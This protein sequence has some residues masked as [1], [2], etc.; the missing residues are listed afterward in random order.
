VVCVFS[1]SLSTFR[2]VFLSGRACPPTKRYFFLCYSR[3]QVLFYII[4]STVCFPSTLYSPSSGSDIFLRGC[5]VL[6][7]YSHPRPSL[8]FKS[9][10]VVL[11]FVHIL[12]CSFYWYFSV[13]KK[14]PLFS[15]HIL[16]CT[17]LKGLLVHHPLWPFPKFLILSPC[18]IYKFDFPIPQ[19]YLF[20]QNPWIWCSW[21]ALSAESRVTTLLQ[22]V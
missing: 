17:S 14:Q 1:L 9:S 6:V 16:C 3:S 5:F 12:L 7:I 2:S 4:C 22:Q 10:S 21:S 19:G 18:C 8:F 20:S 13:I 11:L 15:H